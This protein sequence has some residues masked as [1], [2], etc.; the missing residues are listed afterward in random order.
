MR[1]AHGNSTPLPLGTHLRVG[2]A[3]SI[4][5][6][7]LCLPIRSAPLQNGPAR[8]APH[9]QAPLLSIPGHLGLAHAV[10][11]LPCQRETQGSPVV[12]PAHIRAPPRLADVLHLRKHLV[13]PLVESCDQPMPLSRLVRTQDLTH[14]SAQTSGIESVVPDVLS[15]TR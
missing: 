10:P 11:C 5:L 9:R 14:T 6:P 13:Q 3:R 2:G 8:H 1:S 7:R 4:P 15:L 12:S